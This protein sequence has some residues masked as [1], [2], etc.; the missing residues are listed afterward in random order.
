MYVYKKKSYSL[1]VYMNKTRSLHVVLLM[2][3]LWA[4]TLNWPVVVLVGPPL[5]VYV[6][7]T[8]SVF[9]GPPMGVYVAMTRKGFEGPTF[10]GV[11]W[12]DT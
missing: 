2:A 5:G 10:G 3:C 9:Y 1:H 8:R 11:H 4:Y 12:T 6:K 7:L